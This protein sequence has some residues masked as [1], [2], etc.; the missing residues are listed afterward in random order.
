MDERTSI[1]LEMGKTSS[2]R[3]REAS[4]R[5]LDLR[6]SHEYIQKQVWGGQPLQGR[7]ADGLIW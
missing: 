6:D 7:V 2:N 3:N 5:N 4:F 1:L